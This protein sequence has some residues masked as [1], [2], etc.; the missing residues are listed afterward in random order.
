MLKSQDITV[1]KCYVNQKAR[2]A[3]EVVEEFDHHRVRYN[4]FNLITGRLIPAPFQIS[5]KSD[6]ARWADREAKPEEIS[7][8][9]SLEPTT[10]FEDLPT[11]D[12]KAAKLEF[13]KANMLE[14]VRH[15]TIQ[16]G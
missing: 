5:W 4:A 2:V 14:T 1:G 11:R 10:W 12:A 7:R 6:L 16:R 15:N 13:T 8:I 9:H 3:R